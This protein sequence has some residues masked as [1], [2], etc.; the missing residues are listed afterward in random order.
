ML[1]IVEVTQL[2]HCT[3]SIKTEGAPVSDKYKLTVAETF[4]FYNIMLDKS[5]I[6]YEEAVIAFILKKRTASPG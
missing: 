1:K 4:L 3:Q 2:G 6:R 5:N